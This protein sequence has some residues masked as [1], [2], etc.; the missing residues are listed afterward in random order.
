MKKFKKIS[1]FQKFKKII[2]LRNQPN[3]RRRKR[4]PNVQKNRLPLRPRPDPN[5]KILL[6]KNRLQQG[7]N[8]PNLGPTNH[9]NNRPSKKPPPTKK[10]SQ[11][12]D[13]RFPGQKPNQ[14]KNHSQHPKDPR[15]GHLHALAPLQRG[16]SNPTRIHPAQKRE[17]FGPKPPR[18][19]KYPNGKIQSK[20]QHS[21]HF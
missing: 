17:Q 3:L 13:H 6:T 1:K 12:S 5:P 18:R 21:D 4:K 16:Q 9:R 2:F 10:I 15:R 7:P 11:K 19:Q 20:R 14:S 8:N